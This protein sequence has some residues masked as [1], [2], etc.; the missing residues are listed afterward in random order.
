[1]QTVLHRDLKVVQGAPL[2]PTLDKLCVHFFQ[3][4]YIPFNN[5]SNS[6]RF[7]YFTCV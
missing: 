3:W 7:P 1:M 2:S 4:I 6:K 5:I